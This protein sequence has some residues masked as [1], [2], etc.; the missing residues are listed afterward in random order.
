MGKTIQL[1]RGAVTITFEPTPDIRRNLEMDLKPFKFQG[2]KT[3]IKNDGRGE[4]TITL[5]WHPYTDQSQ[6]REEKVDYLISQTRGGG[7]PWTFHWG[8]SGESGARSFNVH[9]KSIREMERGGETRDLTVI[10]VMKVI[11]S[12]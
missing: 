1:E 10:V 9:V 4:M 6:T 3:K 8:V 11:E 7:D 2:G 12:G 5:I